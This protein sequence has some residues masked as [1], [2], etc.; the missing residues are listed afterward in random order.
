MEIKNRSRNNTIEADK[1]NDCKSKKHVFT[2]LIASKSN[3]KISQVGLGLGEVG[4]LGLETKLVGD[5]GDGVDHAVRSGVG[6]LAADFH[7]FVLS[8]NILQ[9]AGFLGG[10][11]VTGLNAEGKVG[12]GL[13][14]SKIRLISEVNVDFLRFHLCF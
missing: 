8:A 10:L 2:I 13:K 1:N 14:R 9:L 5:V 3:K 7:S 12:T 4:T 6:V 11:A